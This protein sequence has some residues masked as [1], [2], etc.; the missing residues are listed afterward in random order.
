MLATHNAFGRS[1]A[2]LRRARSLAGWMACR[3]PHRD[4]RASAPAD[5]RDPCHSHQPSMARVRAHEP[6]NPFGFALLS[7][8]NQ[9]AAFAGMSRL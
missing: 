2:K 7:G 4:R 1:A 6:V 9:A 3:P 5:A 8:A